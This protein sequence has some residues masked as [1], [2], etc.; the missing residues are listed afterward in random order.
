M[1]AWWKFSDQLASVASCCTKTSVRLFSCHTSYNLSSHN[2]L[3]KLR[4][5]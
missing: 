3:K 1:T 4:P 5:S 2:K